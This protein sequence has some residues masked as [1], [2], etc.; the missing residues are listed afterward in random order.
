MQVPSV[1][2]VR[3]LSLVT[4][5]L[6][7]LDQSLQTIKSGARLTH[8]QKASLALIMTG[9]IV[10]EMLNWAA[11]G[12]RSLGKAKP[13]QL[14]WM[15]CN[16]KIAWKLLLQASIKHI[17]A[18]YGITSGTTA[19]RKRNKALKA[20]LKYEGEADYR[21]LVAF[22]LSYRYRQTVLTEV[23]RRGFYSELEK[24]RRLGPV[25][26]AAG[27]RRM[28]AWPAVRSSPV[29]ASGTDRPA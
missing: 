18:T 9:I 16:A 15:L 22:D 6:D 23:A 12:R 1:V 20:A 7:A 13:S 4:Q 27:R 21:Y 3:P 17:L 24:V 10:T 14:L 26:Q 2:L 19:W 29:A 25:E 11:F 28:R 8:C 5:F